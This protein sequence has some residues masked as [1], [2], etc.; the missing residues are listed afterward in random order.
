MD[1][2]LDRINNDISKIY[3]DDNNILFDKAI[4]EVRTEFQ[5]RKAVEIYRERKNF[6]IRDKNILLS[7]A[8][9]P[10]DILWK[11]Y[12]YTD[13]VKKRQAWCIV[14]GI[15]TVIVDVLILGGL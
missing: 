1:A 4:V 11:N 6:T 10:T 15:I 5:Q 13:H 7:H 12:Q 14:F 3:L 8:R 9:E 2:E